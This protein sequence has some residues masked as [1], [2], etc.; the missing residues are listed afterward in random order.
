[1][2]QIRN[3]SCSIRRIFR[4]HPNL[5]AET[6]LPSPEGPVPV[7]FKLFGWRNR[8]HFLLSPFQESKAFRSLKAAVFLLEKGL[9][10]PLPVGAYEVR[11]WGF[12]RENAY[13]TLSLGPKSNV[14]DFL[15]GLSAE[16]RLQTL[17]RL[18]RELRRMHDAGLVHRDL[19]QNN[20]FICLHE[21][22]VR[23]YLLDLNRARFLG[24]VP[25]PLRITDLAR[26]RL[27]EKDFRALLLGYAPDRA[28]FG[29]L[30]RLLTW[31]RKMNGLYDW[32]KSYRNR[33]LYRPLGWR[34]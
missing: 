19:E 26:L 17:R 16:A 4:S 29:K 31:K 21:Q 23:F 32:L 28:E 27:S 25:G 10:T 7:V 15:R 3:R 5:V 9:N 24:S 18:G 6:E 33:Y 2:S 13:L 8:L 14:K 1:M 34:K 30:W 20:L 22:P 12:V 11:K